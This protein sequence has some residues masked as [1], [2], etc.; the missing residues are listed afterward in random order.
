MKSPAKQ[1]EKAV[2]PHIIADGMNTPDLFNLPPSSTATPIQEHVKA[3]DFDREENEVPKDESVNQILNV[4]GVE[5]QSLDDGSQADV[6]VILQ[7]S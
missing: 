4:K 7:A 3:K 1:D 6:S 2:P 5:G